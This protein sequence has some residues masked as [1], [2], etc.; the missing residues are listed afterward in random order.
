[1]PTF[2]CNYFLL[3]TR[4]P[5]TLGGP[6]DFACPAY[7]IVTPLAV[8]TEVPVCCAA[9][10]ARRG[11]PAGGGHA[12]RRRE[13]QARRSGAERPRQRGQVSSAAR[14]QSGSRPQLR[15]GT[16]DG[17]AQREGTLPPSQRTRSVISNVHSTFFTNYPIN[18]LMSYDLCPIYVALRVLP[19]RPSACRSFS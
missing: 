15:Q 10:L 16:G 12:G 4:G 11:L 2:Y 5:L 1:M 8:G 17:C 13:A 14:Q 6:L 7:P 19:V 3:G 18:Q 9:F